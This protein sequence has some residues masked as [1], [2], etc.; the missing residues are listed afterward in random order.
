MLYTELLHIPIYHRYTISLLFSQFTQNFKNKLRF[1]KGSG[2]V[3]SEITIHG[4][5]QERSNAAASFLEH[6]KCQE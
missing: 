2:S 3:H 1:Y 5:F 4:V 6:V